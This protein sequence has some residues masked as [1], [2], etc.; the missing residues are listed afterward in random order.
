MAEKYL[1]DKFP[2]DAQADIFRM[3]DGTKVVKW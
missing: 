2:Y 1:G 3:S